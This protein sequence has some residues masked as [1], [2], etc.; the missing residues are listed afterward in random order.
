ME[1]AAE[2]IKKFL[3]QNNTSFYIPPFQRSYAWGRPEINR[4]FNDISK[5][6]ESERNDAVKDKVE[7]FFGVLVLKTET[8]GTAAQTMVIDGQQRLTTTLLLLIAVRDCESDE[9]QKTDIE[10]DFLK[11]RKSDFPEKIKLKQVAS[12][13][14]AY[15][16]LILNEEQKP[17]KVTA[18]YNTFRDRMREKDYTTD[19][20]LT[21]LDRVNIACVGLEKGPYK[22]ENPQLIFETLNSLGKPLSFADL[23]RNYILLG[24]EPADQSKIYEKTWS[25]N[26]EEV[27]KEKTSHF[28]RDYMQYKESKSFKVVSDNNT[29]ELY[30]SFKELVENKFSNKQAF[31]DDIERYAPWYHWIIELVSSKAISPDA[32]KNK[33]IKELLRNI[34][35]DI[36]AEA[37][38]PLVLGILEYHQDGFNKKK[39]SDDQLIE[40]LNVIRTYLM[41]RRVMGLTQGENKEIACLCKDINGNDKGNGYLLTDARS[42]M[43][44][45]LSERSRHLRIPNDSD[46]RRKLESLNFYEDLNKYCRLILGKIEENQSPKVSV[47]FRNEKITI[48]HIMPQSIDNSNSWQEEIGENWAEVHKKY[49][50]NIGNLILTEF[51]G[52]LGKKSL[53]DKKQI[54]NDSNLRYRNDVLDRATWNENDILDHQK[55]MIDRFLETFSLPPDMQNAENYDT[56]NA[57]TDTVTISLLEDEEDEIKETVPGR[58]PEKLSIEDE[59]FDVKSWQGMYLEFLRWLKNNKPVEFN[60]ILDQKEGAFFGNYSLVATKQMMADII[61][62]APEMKDRY[63]RL[64]DDKKYSKVQIEDENP[65]YIFINQSAGAFISRI[66]TAMELADMAEGSV[67]IELKPE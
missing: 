45:L 46:I 65:I 43:L 9:K 30:A 10:E 62:A 63:K 7:H 16:A 58:K 3:N 14:D 34:F 40:A 38:K 29:K 44:K 19:E 64:A 48:E 13:W 60:N 24:M 49:Q 12:D 50:H 17:G 32:N 41:R 31:I 1:V 61:E 22:G 66:C 35:H 53:K 8:K 25:P 18:G 37:F 2:N 6:I 57:A 67:K 28:F 56:N 11:N 15:K 5:I 54:L 55:E 20:Y 52:E 59:S 26:I 42:E 4:F 51:N 33:K 36:K 23:I 21:A 39:L 47:D 27:L